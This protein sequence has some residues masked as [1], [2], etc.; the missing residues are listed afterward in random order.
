MFFIAQMAELVDAHASGACGEIHGSS[1][2]LLGT[3]GVLS[4]DFDIFILSFV[5]GIGEILPI[6]SSV[7]LHLFSKLFHIESFS[8]SLK[9]SLHVGSL[10]TLLLYFQ[11]E[12]LNIFRGIFSSKTKLSE[13]YFWQLLLATIPVTI[14]GYFARDFVKEFDSPK[15]MGAVCIIFGIILLIFD[16]ISCM[17][18]RNDKSI[19]PVWQAFILG[20]FQA[21]AIFPGISRFGICLTSARMLL[22]DRKKAIHFSLLLAIPSIFGSLTLEFYESFNRNN[23]NIFEKNNL[24]GVA[25]TALIGILAIFPSIKFMENRGFFL[26]TIYRVIVGAAIFFL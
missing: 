9:I 2:L 16:R 12:I 25:V 13:T 10:L 8:F 17:M 23:L 14:L 1:S 26:I 18:K 21:V 7:N 3:I 4:M 6:S 20:C 22:I 11:R 5:Q 19:V 15:I 24:I